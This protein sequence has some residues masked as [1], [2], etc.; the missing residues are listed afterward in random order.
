M[1]QLCAM[2]AN[3]ACADMVIGVFPFESESASEVV[4]A[5]QT[6]STPVN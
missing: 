1:K 3:E 4:E 2:L 5:S 6:V